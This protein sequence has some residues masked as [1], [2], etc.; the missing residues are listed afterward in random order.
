MALTIST[1]ISSRTE[2]QIQQMI[3]MYNLDR[4]L[5]QKLPPHKKSVSLHDK[6]ELL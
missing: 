3:N 5:K 4:K 1:A 2:V 6:I